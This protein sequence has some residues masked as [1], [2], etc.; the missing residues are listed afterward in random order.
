MRRHKDRG[1]LSEWHARTNPKVKRTNAA[2]VALERELANEKRKHEASKRELKRKFER[3]LAVLK[4]ELAAAN[5][6]IENLR[7]VRKR[8]DYIRGHHH[9]TPLHAMPHHCA[10]DREQAT[11]PRRHR[12]Q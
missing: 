8:L 9:A 7:Q 10:A 11:Q 1:D 5:S 2:W 3:E 4:R 12:R 6:T